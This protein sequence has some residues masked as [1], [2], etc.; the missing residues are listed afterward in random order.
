MHPQLDLELVAEVAGAAWL[1]SGKEASCVP[2]TGVSIDSRT[3]RP[4]ELFVALQ[5]PRFDGHR[6]IHQ[7]LAQGAAAVLVSAPIEGTLPLPI[8]K[9]DDTLAALSAVAAAWRKKVAPVVV[10]VTGSSGKTT[11]KEMIAALLRQKYRVHATSG[12]LNNHVGLPLTLLAMPGDCQALVVEMGMSA[13]GEIAHLARLAQPE[14]GVVTN[15]QPAHMANFRNLEAIAEAKS[16]LLEALPSKGL[17]IIPRDG[18]FS[19]LLRSRAPRVHTFGSSPPADRGD[20]GLG[21]LRHEEKGIRFEVLRQ[22]GSFWVTLPQPGVHMAHNA[23]AAI[24]VAEHLGV[25]GAEMAE[26]FAN[27]QTPPGR[28]RMQWARGGFQVV[29]DTY[30]ANPGSVAAALSAL[31]S[32]RQAGRRVAV[33]G[34]MLELGSESA[35]LHAG[36]ADAVR[37]SGVD[38]LLTAGKGMAALHEA[39]KG[40]PA[41]KVF[42]QE[43]PADWVGK[44]LPL[45]EPGDLVLVK[46][47]RGMRMETIIHDLLE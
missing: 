11:V 19:S 43:T 5:G 24:L 1:P 42:H 25:G 7:A 35:A 38:L 34:D 23:L 36:M 37:V 47:S 33:L 46:G 20:L 27:F 6:F 10:G 16:E 22:E 28:G 4:G 32:Q 8:L 14:T 21:L 2:L 13:K 26:A 41:V 18:A 29:D 45:L 39:L 15:I 30:N 9:V 17:G 12:N 40:D 3:L 31:G 44:I